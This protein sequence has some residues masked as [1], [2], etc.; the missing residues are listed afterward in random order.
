VAVVADGKG[1]YTNGNCEEE[2]VARPVAVDFEKVAPVMSSDAL[3]KWVAAR[4]A[5]VEAKAQVASL[6][7]AVREAERLHEAEVAR[8]KEKIA[9]LKGR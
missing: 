8:R 2:S 1:T 6:G 5:L 3:E 4:T 9:E 7:E